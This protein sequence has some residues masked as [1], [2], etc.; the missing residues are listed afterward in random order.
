MKK[1]FPEKSYTNY[2]GETFP[3]LFVKVSISLDRCS[4]VLY[5]LLLFYGKLRTIKKY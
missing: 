1:C 5:S 4:T 3:D 2:G